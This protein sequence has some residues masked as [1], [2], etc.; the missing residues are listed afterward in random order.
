MATTAER[1]TIESVYAHRDYFSY[2]AFLA[3]KFITHFFFES[4][5]NGF[6]SAINILEDEILCSPNVVHL[7]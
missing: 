2:T 1:S 4:L 3:A 5:Q 7:W 6:D